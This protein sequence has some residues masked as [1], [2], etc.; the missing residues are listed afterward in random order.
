MMMMMMMMMMIH[1]GIN[2]SV[3][4]IYPEICSINRIRV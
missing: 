1:D 3:P 2:A 4:N